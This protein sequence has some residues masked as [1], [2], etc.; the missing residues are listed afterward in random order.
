MLVKTKV[1]TEV[2]TEIELPYFM[3]RVTGNLFAILTNDKALKIENGLV[4]THYPE[5]VSQFI[6]D[7]ET[8]Q[9][10]AEEFTTA[11]DNAIEQLQSLK[12]LFFTK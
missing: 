8:V 9:I 6:G 10:T 2:E 11:Y 3:K 7:G 12:T 5:S 4:S 1:T